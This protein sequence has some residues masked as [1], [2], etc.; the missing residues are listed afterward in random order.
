MVKC[1]WW[2]CSSRV[3]ICHD[4]RDRQSCKICASCVNFSRKQCA[5]LQNLHRSLRFPLSDFALNFTRAVE[6]L[7]KYLNYCWCISAVSLWIKIVQ[8]YALFVCKIS[9]PKIWSCKFF[10]KSRV[11]QGLNWVTHSI[12]GLVCLEFLSKKTARESFVFTRLVK[13]KQLG[14][15]YEK[16]Q[17]TTYQVVALKRD[18]QVSNCR[19]LFAWSNITSHNINFRVMRIQ[20]Y[21]QQ[22][23]RSCPQWSV[24]LVPPL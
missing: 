17:N 21:L 1:K 19:V 14:Q 2:V 24:S 18:Q 22:Q 4:H 23:G 12:L 9:G 15:G 13:I 10:D 11:W 16:Q 20:P 3:E 7:Q 6:F 8:I 5:F